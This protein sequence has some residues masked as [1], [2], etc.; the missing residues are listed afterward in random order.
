ML[1]FYRILYVCYIFVVYD[2]MRVKS[3]V[4]RS[5]YTIHKAVIS[6]IA[7]G[8]TCSHP[9]IFLGRRGIFIFEGVHTLSAL[10]NPCYAWHIHIRQIAWDWP[11][12]VDN[13]EWIIRREN[14]MTCATRSSR[15]GLSFYVL[16]RHFFCPVSL[17]ELK[18]ENIQREILILTCWKLFLF[19][20]LFFS[21]TYTI[22][23]AYERIINSFNNDSILI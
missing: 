5:L 1:Y 13:A 18:H 21:L 15:L 16:G 19:K 20:L 2:Q 9:P 22:V 4:L 7:I 17:E 10:M 11:Q 23:F 3:C 6:L 8:A 12:S 14:N